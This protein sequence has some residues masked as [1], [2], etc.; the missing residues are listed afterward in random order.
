MLELGLTKC[1]VAPGNGLQFIA[2]KSVITRIIECDSRS[3]DPVLQLPDTIG[4]SGAPANRAG[5]LIC[6]PNSVQGNAEDA[7]VHYAVN[8]VVII[9]NKAFITDL[10][11]YNRRLPD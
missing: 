2:L 7:V 11:V 9:N 10:I 3:N 8:R 5:L 6:T 4:R 1:N